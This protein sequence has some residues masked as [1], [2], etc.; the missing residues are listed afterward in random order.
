M[1]LAGVSKRRAGRFQPGEYRGSVFST[2]FVYRS[3]MC[4]FALH[5]VLLQATLQM[6]VG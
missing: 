6:W 4:A 5:T 2:P 1:E 3:L